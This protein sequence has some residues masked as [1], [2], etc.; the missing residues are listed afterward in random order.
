VLFVLGLF[1]VLVHGRGLVGLRGRG[2]LAHGHSLLHDDL[3]FAPGLF[4]KIG[5]LLLQV[6]Y[7]CGTVGVYPRVLYIVY[8]S[9]T[10]S[11]QVDVDPSVRGLVVLQG[12]TGDALADGALGDTE[13][14]GRFLY[15]ESVQWSCHG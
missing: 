12:A 8:P 2:E 10:T 6:R 3:V 1:F 15:G 9:S 14:A 7:E 4:P 11:V 5:D 13:K